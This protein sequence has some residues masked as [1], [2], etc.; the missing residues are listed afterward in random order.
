VKTIVLGSQSL[1]LSKTNSVFFYVTADGSLGPAG[2]YI[3]RET[4]HANGFYA[5][6]EAG[7]QSRMLA[8]GTSRAGYGSNSSHNL[9]ARKLL[10]EGRSASATLLP[11]FVGFGGVC[12]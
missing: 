8:L 11:A 7:I 2:I 12:L 5:P 1:V 9:Y 10:G 6:D 4:V 3:L